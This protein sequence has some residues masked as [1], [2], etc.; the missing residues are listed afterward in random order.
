MDGHKLID[1]LNRLKTSIMQ[2]KNMKNPIDLQIINIA[3]K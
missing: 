3:F 2:T 1:V